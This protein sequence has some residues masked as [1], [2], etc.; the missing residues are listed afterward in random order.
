MGSAF[1]YIAKTL[2]TLHPSKLIYGL[3]IAIAAVITPI[4]ILA[5]IKL[6]QRDLSSILEGA[7][8]TINARMR[9]T[10]R[11]GRMFTQTPLYAIASTKRATGC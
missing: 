11:Q 9:L 10:F 4:T 3:I 8:W 7:G 5:I 1:A 2:S 6:R